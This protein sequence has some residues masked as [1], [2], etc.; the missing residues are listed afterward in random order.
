MSVIWGAFQSLC[1]P[2]VLSGNI[3]D[4]ARLNILLCRASVPGK[5]VSCFPDGLEQETKV[6]FNRLFIYEYSD[7]DGSQIGHKSFP[8][9]KAS[10]VMCI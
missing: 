6:C 7:G 3:T 8:S 4:V 10:T 5:R 9:P 2:R 1:L